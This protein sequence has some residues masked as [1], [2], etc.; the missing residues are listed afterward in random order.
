VVR[1]GRN[2]DPT[3]AHVTLRKVIPIAAGVGGGSANAAGALV[4]LNRIWSLGLSKPDLLR[5]AAALGSDIPFFLTGGT[6]IGLGRG[7]QILPLRPIRR[8]GVVLIK[9]AFGISTA[10]AYRWLD[11]DRAAGNE[12]PETPTNLNVGWPAPLRLVNDLEPP[13]ARRHGAIGEA[14]RAARQAGAIAAAMTGSGSAVFALF[15]PAV[16]AVAARRLRRPE[17]VVHATTT[18]SAPEAGRLIPL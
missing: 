18:L 8:L 13:V 3:G 2:G 9:P 15:P 12:G 5:V 10:D 6:A 14:V 4:G 7:D 11:E 16:A 1:G 17:W